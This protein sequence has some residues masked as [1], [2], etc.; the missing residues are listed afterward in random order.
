LPVGRAARQP[1]GLAV[2]PRELAR[3]EPLAAGPAARTVSSAKIDRIRAAA[4]IGGGMLQARVGGDWVD[5]VRYSNARASR[6][7]K[8]ARALK[9][10]Q[11]VV[12]LHE[13]APVGGPPAGRRDRRRHG[14]QHPCRP[15]SALMPTHISAT[16][17]PV[18]FF[19]ISFSSFFYT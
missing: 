6:F 15:S 1:A 12:D 19:S 17:E 9:D 8:L 5:L 18:L 16:A 11:V 13:F 14:P 2:A 3:G 10:S 7:H 4:G